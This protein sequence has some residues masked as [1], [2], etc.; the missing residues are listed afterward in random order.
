VFGFTLEDD[1][2]DALVARTKIAIPDMYDECFNYKGDIELTIITERVDKLLA[3]T[4]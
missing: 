3:V 1:S 4:A 2:F